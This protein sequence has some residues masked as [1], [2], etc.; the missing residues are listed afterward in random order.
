[1]PTPHGPRVERT[2]R[3][4]RSAMGGRSGSGAQRA[5]GRGRQGVRDRPGRNGDPARPAAPRLA[6]LRRRTREARLMFHPPDL[7][8]GSG[9]GSGAASL[10]P[11]AGTRASPR[12]AASLTARGLGETRVAAAAPEAAWGSPAA[13]QLWGCEPQAHAR[14]STSLLGHRPDPDR[15]RREGEKV[16]AL[17]G[18]HP[19]GGA[20]KGARIASPHACAATRLRGTRGASQPKP[21]PRARGRSPLPASS[22]RRGS[23]EKRARAPSHSPA[24]LAQRPVRA[25]SRSRGFRAARAPARLERIS[26]EPPAREVVVLRQPAKPASLTRDPLPGPPE[27]RPP[28]RLVCSA[29][30]H[31]VDGRVGRSGAD[32]LACTAAGC[33]PERTA[34]G[35]EEAGCR[36]P[37]RVGQ[38]GD[39]EAIPAPPLCPG[40]QDGLRPPRGH[41]V[42]WIG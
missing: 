42:A 6:Q 16:T 13:A 37:K 10:P 14:P 7:C 31:T 33:G 38:H 36:G 8:A 30:R 23:P 39:S 40:V 29:A 3:A 2:P 18:C 34:Q 27:D 1:M 25:A 5:G 17:A 11:P 4:A 32:R 12:A 15:L 19:A 41:G 26:P 9:S 20:R 21:T 28:C 24:L 22:A 35:A